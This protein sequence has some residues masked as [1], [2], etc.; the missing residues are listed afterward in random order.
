LK[1]FFIGLLGQESVCF[2]NIRS[3]YSP[4]EAPSDNQQGFVKDSIEPNSNV[5]HPGI[6]YQTPALI[7]GFL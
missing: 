5:K 4:L 7:A 3:Y 6:W 2:Y 1:Y